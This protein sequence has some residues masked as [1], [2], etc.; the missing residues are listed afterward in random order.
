MEAQDELG[1][2]LVKKP[3]KFL[4]NSRRLFEKLHVQCVNAT[5]PA[6]Q[7]HRHVHL[8]GG[9]ARQAQIYPKA[10]CKAVC[11]GIAQQRKDDENGMREIAILDRGEIKAAASYA[12]GLHPELGMCPTDHAEAAAWLHEPEPEQWAR[13][14]VSGEPLDSALV[15][16]ARAEEIDYFRQMGVYRKVPVSKCIEV[17]GRRPIGVRWI[18]VNK[19]DVDSP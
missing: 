5:V 7:R 14:D 19:G 2:G 8:V 16:R 15:R 13:D 12:H 17:T 3:T 18:D 9:R 4:T 11:A 1:K 6:D 10:L